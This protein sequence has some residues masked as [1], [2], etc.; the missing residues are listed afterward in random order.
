[1]TTALEKPTWF[2]TQCIIGS[3][4]TVIV[5]SQKYSLTYTVGSKAVSTLADHV[6]LF[7]DFSAPVHSVVLFHKDVK[8]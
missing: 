8:R 3:K 7:T 2:D 5:N 4:V 6:P 1:V